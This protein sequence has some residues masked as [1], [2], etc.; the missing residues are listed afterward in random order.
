[1]SMSLFIELAP[2]ERFEFC[3]GRHQAFGN[4]LASEGAKAPAL[5]RIEMMLIDFFLLYLHIFSSFVV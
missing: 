4:E 1:M 3:Q 2:D 5:V